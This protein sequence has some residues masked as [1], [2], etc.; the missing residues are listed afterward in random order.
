MWIPVKVSF[1]VTFQWLKGVG[2]LFKVVKKHACRSDLKKKC[3]VIGPKENSQKALKK[4]NK[5]KT[6]GGG[7]LD[8]STMDS[9]G[10]NLLMPVPEKVGLEPSTCPASPW[11]KCLFLL[12]A[13]SPA[14]CQNKPL[15]R[16]PPQAALPPVSEAQAL[17]DEGKKAKGLIVRILGSP[18]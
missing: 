12:A 18:F 9:P 4:A 15:K 1:P 8:G 13:L 10:A 14:R 11:S 2:Y 3:Y 5:I 17:S 6:V 7:A 16:I